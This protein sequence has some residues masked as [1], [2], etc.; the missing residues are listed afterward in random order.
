MEWPAC[1]PDLNPIELP[2]ETP[3]NSCGISVSVL[4]M[5]E[6]THTTR[7]ADL[8]QM[9]VEEWDAIPQQPVTKLVT[10]MRRRYQ[11]VVV[12]PHATEA[13]VS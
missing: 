11:A 1:I 2:I 12:I 9:L 8:R 3:L 4:F 10:I 6:V 7:M 13:P 5:P